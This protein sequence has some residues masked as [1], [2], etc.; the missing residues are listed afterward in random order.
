MGAA[1]QKEEMNS[2]AAEADIDNKDTCEAIAECVHDEQFA[3]YTPWRQLDTS[4]V[5]PIAIPVGKSAQSLY[6]YL[7]TELQLA[8][9]TCKVGLRKARPGATTT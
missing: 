6:A 7:Q 4:K 1:E 9:S 8:R 3:F 5:N 2:L